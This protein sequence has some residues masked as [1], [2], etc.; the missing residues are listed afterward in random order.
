VAETATQLIDFS[1]LNGWEDDD[2]A[3]ALDVFRNTCMD[4][5]EPDWQ[6]L[7]AI[8]AT[9]PDARTFFELFFQTG[10]DRR[11]PNRAFHRLFRARA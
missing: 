2:H 9:A 4:F 5:D 1:E 11:G 8:A 3:A 10:S 6:G 7:C